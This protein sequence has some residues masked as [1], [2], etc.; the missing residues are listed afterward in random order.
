MPIMLSNEPVRGVIKKSVT[1]HRDL[2][3]MAVVYVCWHRLQTNPDSH[4]NNQPD[5][6]TAQRNIIQQSLLMTILLLL[7]LLT[8]LLPVLVLL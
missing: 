8:L 4:K 7:L 2:R 1:A 5:F 6:L 3:R